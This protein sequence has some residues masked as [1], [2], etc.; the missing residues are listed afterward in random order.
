[1][2]KSGEIMRKYLKAYL[3]PILIIMYML[4]NIFVLNTH[5]HSQWLPSFIWV[6]ITVLCFKIYGNRNRT[7]D[8]YVDII[9][10]I[11]IYCMGYE[12]IIYLSGLFLGFV[13]SP[14]SMDPITMIK[15]IAPLIVMIV[16][17]ELVRFLVISRYKND[18]KVMVTTTISFV[19]SEIAIGMIAYDLNSASEVLKMITILVAGSITKNVLCSYLAFRADYKPAILYRC[20][21]ELIIY[22]VPIYP[23]LGDYI[24]AMVSMLFP[25]LLVVSLMALFEKKKYRQPKKSVMELLIMWVPTVAIVLFVLGLQSGIFKYRSMAIGSQSMYP[26]IQKGDVVVIEQYYD[27]EELRSIQEGEVLAFKHD[28]IIVVHRV[29]RITE[30][31]GQLVFKTKGDNNNAEDSYDV[32]QSQ[33]VGVTKFKIPFIGHPS[34]WLS[35]TING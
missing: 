31:N 19:L 24:E 8:K 25:V 32:E 10:L 3:I 9:Q 20:I 18:K 28:N 16:S 12:L 27:E 11:F 5:R 2:L 30:R 22:V 29:V 7:P 4:F 23:N 35:E 17:Q 21:F 6:V 1:M 13:R 26:K 33:V 14:Y 34:V 15:N